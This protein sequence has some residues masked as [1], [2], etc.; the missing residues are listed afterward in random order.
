M[1]NLNSDINWRKIFDLSK[2]NLDSG[3][4]PRVEDEINIE[5]GEA[6]KTTEE[7]LV[8]LEL[9]TNVDA[10]GTN[11]ADV[12]DEQVDSANVPIIGQNTFYPPLYQQAETN[13][14]IVEEMPQI[15]DHSSAFGGQHEQFVVFYDP[16]RGGISL[17]EG[18][19]AANYIAQ[20]YDTPEV[21]MVPW[22]QEIRRGDQLDQFPFSPVQYNS[23][24]YTSMMPESSSTT[25]FGSQQQSDS[26]VQIL[27]SQAPKMSSSLEPIPILAKSNISWS[28]GATSQY[29][30]STSQTL[31]SQ[32]LAYGSSSSTYQGLSL[33]SSSGYVGLSFGSSWNSPIDLDPWASSSPA[34]QGRRGASASTLAVGWARSSKRRRNT[35]QAA[36]ATAAQS[37]LAFAPANER[38]LFNTWINQLPTQN[39]AHDP[40]TFSDPD[41]HQLEAS[42]MFHASR[43]TMDNLNS[44]I[45]WRQIF[46]LSKQIFDPRLPPRVEAKINIEP[47]EAIKTTEELL[48]LLELCTNVDAGGTNVAD[49]GDQQVDSANRP[50]IGQNTFYPPLYLY[51]FELDFSNPSFAVKPAFSR[52]G[53][54]LKL[55]YQGLSL[56]SSSSYVGLSLGSSWNSP[57]DYFGPH[58]LQLNRPT[59]NQAYDPTTSA[60][61][62]LQQ[63]VACSKVSVGDTELFG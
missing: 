14:T 32:E 54:W 59:Q 9:C 26:D 5:P 21:P 7:L 55:N 18:Q 31:P 52:I 4:H 27:A 10:S 12:G 30:S 20:N 36:N 15:E 42:S 13:P 25:I 44:A 62:D 40:T 49:I 33:G 22:I 38:G 58:L 29:S 6:I 43:K 63:L 51:I 48:V 61:P 23:N 8:F 37:L 28:S 56:G 39:Q 53:I 35:N 47:G 57:I 24:A 34:Q 1:D 16:A 50:I 41:L 46:N 45:N 60:N 3:L 17:K 2:Q 19:S 11:V